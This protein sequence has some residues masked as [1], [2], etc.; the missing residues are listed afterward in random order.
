MARKWGEI[1]AVSLKLAQLAKAATSGLTHATVQQK[2][3]LA[4]TTLQRILSGQ[5][6]SRDKIA[7]FAQGLNLPLKPLLD[8]VDEVTPKMDPIELF[9]TVLDT[10]PLTPANK[11]KLM[12]TYHELA[13]QEQMQNEQAA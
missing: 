10:L 1:M 13:E 4:S 2:T 7:M 11:M 3:G 5:V 12:E 6:P 9:S 8:A